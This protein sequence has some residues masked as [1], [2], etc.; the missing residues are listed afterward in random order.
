MLR[1]KVSLYFSLQECKPEKL[2][3]PFSEYISKPTGLRTL[4][5]QQDLEKQNQQ[6]FLG[7]PQHQ[8]KR[9]PP[10]SARL[11]SQ[12]KVGELPPS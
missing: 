9:A 1:T 11:L 6:L 8:F 4:G 3:L 5:E 2:T 7:L 12:N 10:S